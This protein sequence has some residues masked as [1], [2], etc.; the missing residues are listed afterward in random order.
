MV[1]YSGLRCAEKEGRKTA[2]FRSQ[3][4]EA[5]LKA[6]YCTKKDYSAIMGLNMT[7]GLQARRR[8]G[9]ER[10]GTPS[11][12]KKRSISMRGKIITVLLAALLWIPV[13]ASAATSYATPSDIPQG[14]VATPSD[15]PQNPVASPSDLEQNDALHFTVGPTLTLA[16]DIVLTIPYEEGI[17]YY[18]VEFRQGNT[19]KT[20]SY[21]VHDEERGKTLVYNWSTWSGDD[22]DPGVYTVTVT[23]YDATYNPSR[24][25][26]A[27]LEITGVRPSAPLVSA[28]TRVL[29]SETI[30]FTITHKGMTE[31][32][33]RSVGSS[34]ATS[35]WGLWI[36]GDEAIWEPTMYSNALEYEFRAM[37][38]GIWSEWSAPVKVSGYTLGQLSLP[39]VEMK[40]VYQ[41][42]E[43]LH[44]TLKATYPEKT[45]VNVTFYNTVT[46]QSTY[47]NGNPDT[48][49]RAG[50]F[51][52]DAGD[53]MLSVYVNQAKYDNNDYSTFFSVTGQRPAAPSVTMDQPSMHNGG[54]VWATVSAAGVEKAAVDEGPWKATTV[55]EGYDGLV[56][57][58]F[59]NW[60][61]GTTSTEVQYRAL[62]GGCWSEASSVSV[63]IDDA[64]MAESLD[65]PTAQ[66]PE[67]IL[68]GEPLVFSVTL[69]PEAKAVTAGLV[70]VDPENRNTDVLAILYEYVLEPDSQGLYTIPANY[71]MRSGTYRLNLHC[72]RTEDISQQD[73][74]ED[75]IVC[76][77]VQPRSQTITSPEVVLKNQPVLAGTAILEIKAPG[78]EKLTV[79]M[80]D[81]DSQYGVYMDPVIVDAD[82]SG[83]TTY[84]SESIYHTGLHEVRVSA[85]QNGV[86]SDYST[87]VTFPITRLK[88]TTK[89]F[90]VS[91][92]PEEF[93]AGERVTVMFTGNDDIAWYD[94]AIF[95]DGGKTVFRDRNYAPGKSVTFALKAQDLEGTDWTGYYNVSGFEAGKESRY[96]YGEFRVLD[97]TILPTVAAEVSDTQFGLVNLKVSNILGDQIAVSVD[98]G[99]PSLFGL[100]A[101][102]NTMTIPL[103]LSRGTHSIA[104]RTG[105]NALSFSEG[106]WSTDAI[107]T[108]K[109]DVPAAATLWIPVGTK[110]IEDE[111]FMGTAETC[112]VIPEGCV[113]IGAKAFASAPNLIYVEIPVSVSAIDSTA[114]DGIA[115]LTVSTSSGSAAEAFARAR[116]W[117]VEIR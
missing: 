116:G 57:V 88:E 20:A 48:I 37:V 10:S 42:G 65:A 100:N 56:R 18:D 3:A 95:L 35:C 83:V 25:G 39:E 74:G 59:S 46:R 96:A 45:Y 69:P 101:G 113:S 11:V 64:A 12:P 14:P 47:W 9:F 51:G 44:L 7:N 24:T 16:D 104:V 108:V 8:T 98:G 71:F 58:P 61:Y 77:E 1:I 19:V 92:L 105:E 72:Y 34:W 68:V 81:D 54:L 110:Q 87:P 70:E 15:I 117:N 79:M 97:P 17:L 49:D 62:I 50:A 112:V 41:A 114:F 94:V 89:E 33:Y 32:Q 78:A 75:L 28:P 26:H 52:L 82:P 40:D 111:A 109:V 67:S 36:D 13:A 93:S 6:H 22:L 103:K 4:T 23:G 115:S 5:N 53:Y 55:Y 38:D 102:V 31:V 60:V 90:T 2:D 29:K 27:T 80:F 66:V 30:T 91:G 99:K 63:E 86:W 21:W 76:V 73:Y 85:Y 106:H 43:P 107:L 84:V